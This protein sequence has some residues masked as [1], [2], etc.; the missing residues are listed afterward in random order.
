[1]GKSA[2]HL[3]FLTDWIYFKEMVLAVTDNKEFRPRSKY[4]IKIVLI[5]L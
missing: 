4:C 1:M 2:C 5:C 3:V